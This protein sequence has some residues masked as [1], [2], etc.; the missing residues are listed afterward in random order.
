MGLLEGWPPW[1]MATPSFV[2]GGG[3][4]ADL[5]AT[6]SVATRGRHAKTSR[7]DTSNTSSF[8]LKPHI[9]YIGSYFLFLKIIFQTSY[10]MCEK[11]R[12]LK[13]VFEIKTDFI[14]LCGDIFE[15]VFG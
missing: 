6:T 9:S 15:N 10:Q 7:F 5:A 12:V 1:V 3:C 2:R 8:F 14:Y 4:Q 13:S 11:C